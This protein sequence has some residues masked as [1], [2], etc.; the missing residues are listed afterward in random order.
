MNCHAAA[1]VA[2]EGEQLAKGLPAAVLTGVG[3]ELVD[4]A[5]F[6]GRWQFAGAL[7]V[8]A[9]AEQF[10]DDL[11]VWTKPARGHRR[12]HRRGHPQIWKKWRRAQ[13]RG[14]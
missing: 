11:P 10:L 13:R 14:R 6:G 9:V 12:P 4:G 1:V 8:T 5:A 3:E 7:P 2:G